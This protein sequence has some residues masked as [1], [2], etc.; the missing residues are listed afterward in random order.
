MDGGIEMILK[1]RFVLLFFSALF[2]VTGCDDSKSFYEEGFFTEEE[3]SYSFV[4]IANEGE[5]NKIEEEWTKITSNNIKRL[6]KENPNNEYLISVQDDTS[7]NG[8]QYILKRLEMENEEYIILVYELDNIIFKTA[9]IDEY[10]EFVDD[11]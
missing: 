5:L 2:L 1:N 7:Y 3:G 6:Q 4:L 11:L 10:K 8:I 9:S